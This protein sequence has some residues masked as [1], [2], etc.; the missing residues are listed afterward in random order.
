MIGFFR[1]VKRLGRSSSGTA[2]VE[3]ALIAPA[4]IGLML[5]VLQVGMAMQ[6][7]GAIRNVTADTAR[8]AVVQ[9]Q[10]GIRPTNDLLRTQAL[11]IA[12]GAPYLLK[13][14]TLS[15]TVTDAAVQRVAGAREITVTV[16]YQI[17]EVLPLF[18][19]A[20]PTISHTRPVFVL[21]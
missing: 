4:A 17:P 8:Y 7:Y 19:W 1:L 10:R 6:S 21:T 2:L 16:T 15:V 3:F 12:D 13:R 20:S 18:G 5:G 14:E 9:H 11:G